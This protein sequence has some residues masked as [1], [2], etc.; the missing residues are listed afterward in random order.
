M[1][2]ELG[3]ALARDIRVVPVM[4][5]R[6]QLPTSDELPPDLQ[7]LLLRQ[8][9]VLHDET[10]H[11]DVRGLLASLRGERALAITR[12]RRIIAATAAALLLTG[13]ASWAVYRHENPAGTVLPTCPTPQTPSWRQL[14]LDRHPAAD[15]K[16]SDGVLRFSVKD[17]YWQRQGDGW[18]ITL[19]TRMKVVTS[20]SRYHG[21]YRYENI[22]VGEHL[23]DPICS[24]GSRLGGAGAI[25]DARVGFQVTCPPVGRI[26]LVLENGARLPVSD[27]SLAPGPC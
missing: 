22:A 3:V 26:E 10:W 18:Q 6:A 25:G 7:P 24:H 14:A 8:A 11:E 15:E 9:V 1:R 5:G 23:F 20:E 19:S 4:V 17:A 27:R 16:T 12:R 21:Y 2:L 13:A